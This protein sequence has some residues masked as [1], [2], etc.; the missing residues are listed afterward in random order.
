MTPTDFNHKALSQCAIKGNNMMYNEKL[1]VAIKSNGKVLREFKDSVYMSFGSEY[2]ITIKNLNSVRAMVSV[3][4]DGTNMTPDSL[5]INA[6]QQIDFERSLANGNLNI[7]NKFKFIERTSTIEN[8]RG[9]KLEDGLVR[10]E[11]QFEK[12]YQPSPFFTET[13]YP[14][15]T[16]SGG[17]GTGAS[18]SGILRTSSSVNIMNA[19]LS[20]TCTDTI[21]KESIAQNFQNDTGITVPGSLSEQKFITVSSFPVEAT[22]HVIILK[23]LG[24]TPDNKP[25][26]KSITVRSKPKCITCNHQNKAR[27]KFCINCGTSLN[28]YA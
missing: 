7:G 23:L 27:A 20:A 11:Y 1:A 26:I 25:I 2:S 4:I 21:S 9:I 12:I 10:I 15:T 28:I 8:H 18:Y 13:A 17:I 3:F 14:Y 22:K 24:E 6:G 16:L 5:V 19:T